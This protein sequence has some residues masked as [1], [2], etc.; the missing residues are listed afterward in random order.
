MIVKRKDDQL[1]LFKAPG[2]RADAFYAFTGRLRKR[3]A[4]S[5]RSS[6]NGEGGSLS[7]VEKRTPELSVAWPGVK[8]KLELLPWVL[9]Q[10][11]M[12][13]SWV[14]ALPLAV[15]TSKFDQRLS[16]VP[17]AAFVLAEMSVL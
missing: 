4:F 5:K 6:R 17:P 2:E 8:F 16:E 11:G 12:L 1:P 14:Y 10:S 9:P 3:K 15:G 7:I 13:V